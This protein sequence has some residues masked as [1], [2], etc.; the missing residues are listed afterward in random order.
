MK[1][2]LTILALLLSSTS[3]AGEKYHF[4]ITDDV[5]FSSFA[6]TV[7]V[8]QGVPNLMGVKLE[9]SFGDFNVF[10]KYNHTLEPTRFSYSTDADSFNGAQ[11]FALSH[12]DMKFQA[13]FN[14]IN[15]GIS[16]Q[17]E[18]KGFIV[19]TNL[20]LG[21]GNFSARFTDGVLPA[22]ELENSILYTGNNLVSDFNMGL[23]KKYNGVFFNV[24]FGYLFA[25]SGDAGMRADK[26]Y[27]IV[28]N[29]S[30]PEITKG[31]SIPGEL[32][33]SGFKLGFNIGIEF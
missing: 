15:L 20:S 33:Y 28:L 21:R 25:T 16:L 31:S 12:F 10:I 22:D 3:F 8:H 13:E 19:E 6:K 5:L 30:G 27:D 7:G 2:L 1:K 11:S 9:R 14:S 26:D 29:H 24:N 17:Q 4:L 18:F 23:T 32:D